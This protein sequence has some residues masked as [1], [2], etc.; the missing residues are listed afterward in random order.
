MTSGGGHDQGQ[1]QNTTN[2]SDCGTKFVFPIEKISDGKCR[3]FL[4]IPA[5]LQLIQLVRDIEREAR[6]LDLLDQ[7][8]NDRPRAGLG[9]NKPL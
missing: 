2:R 9:L 7:G 5:Y 8:R 6:V 3:K 4:H 1:S